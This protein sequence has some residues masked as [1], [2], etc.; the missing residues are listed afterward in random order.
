MGRKDEGETVFRGRYEHAIDGKG[1]VSLPARWREIMAGH[2]DPIIVVTVSH[3]PCLVAR[4]LAAFREFEER[5]RRQNQFNPSVRRA[6]RHLVGNAQE[7][8]VDGMGRVLVPAALRDYAGLQ[9]EVV[10]IGQVD[11]IEIWA[12]ERW[13][14]RESEDLSHLKDD[15]EALS[16]LGI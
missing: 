12:K 10:F 7:C 14:Q 6:M 3:E 5:L 4:S 8:P 1:R 9:K 15:V 11:Q 13:E 2:D 16:A